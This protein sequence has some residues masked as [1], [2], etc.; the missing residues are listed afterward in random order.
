MVAN[1][2]RPGA[3]RWLQSG[4]NGTR[5]TMAEPMANDLPRLESMSLEYGSR[6]C[7]MAC[8]YCY[9][10]GG[11][12]RPESRRQA[13]APLSVVELLRVVYE[14]TALG[15]GGVGIIGPYEPLQ[16]PGILALIGGLRGRGL[17]VTVFT[18]G[19][20][21]TEELARQL[22]KYDVTVALTVHSLRAEVH[23]SLTERAGSYT[24]AMHG[25]ELLLAKGYD[26]KRRRILIQSVVLRQNIDDLPNVW[27]WARRS[28][29]TPFLERLTAQGAGR[30][31]VGE[32]SIAPDAF[33]AF[34]NR[35]LNIDRAEFGREWTAHPPWVGEACSRH[36][37][38]CHLTADGYLQPCT[39]VDIPIGNV[40]DN[41]LVDI[42]CN[43][44]VLRDLRNIRKTIK[45]ACRECVSHDTCYGCRGQ[46]YQ[47]TG[48]YLAADPCCWNNPA[49]CN[50]S[51]SI[52]EICCGG[53]DETPRTETAS[54]IAEMR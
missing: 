23:D 42:L 22:A 1:L 25:L 26:Q 13:Q 39:G 34:C 20:C 9:V 29:F 4:G 17:R 36:L 24:S 47:L 8:S 45:G 33:R 37:D 31:N 32:L 41:N 49:R 16:E 54:S 53:T 30:Q 6:P 50:G 10:R 35:I 3:C 51:C 15:L 14:A 7:G 12:R 38:S 46:A 18:K 27:R 40:R 52:T 48:D 28:G 2:K 21:I 43:S 44:S 5:K 19:H 11:T